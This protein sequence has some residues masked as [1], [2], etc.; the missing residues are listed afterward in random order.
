MHF[1]VR[2]PFLI[3]GDELG[4]LGLTGSKAGNREGDGRRR[5]RM[6]MRV[7]SSSGRAADHGVIT[8]I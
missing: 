6:R 2:D 5:I 8:W 3:R 1:S 7:R 4:D